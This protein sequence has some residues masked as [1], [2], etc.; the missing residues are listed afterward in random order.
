MKTETRSAAEDLKIIVENVSDLLGS[1]DPR[2][3]VAAIN[4][5]AAGIEQLEKRVVSE[6]QESGMTW[7]QI[8]RVYGVSRQAVHRRFAET[9]V[10][11]EFFDELVASLDEPADLVDT[12]ARTAER[13][14]SSDEKR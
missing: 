9:V 13:A 8:G 5:L 12:L 3:R 1:D 11:A 10:P 6:A 2:A 14:N 4:Q 7:D